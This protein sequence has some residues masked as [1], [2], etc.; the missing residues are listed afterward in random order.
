MEAVSSL[1]LK[2]FLC[3]FGLKCDFQNLVFLSMSNNLSCKNT[4]PTKKERER[5]NKG[6]NDSPF[7]WKN[8]NKRPT[9]EHKSGNDSVKRRSFVSEAFFSG[10]KLAE[11]LGRFWDDV[12]P[13]LHRDPASVV[14]ADGNV[15]VNARG[16]WGRH[17]WLGMC[18]HPVY[19]IHALY[20]LCALCLHCQCCINAEFTLC[21]CCVH[22]SR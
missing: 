18:S 22:C 3:K 5:G 2:L 8:V 19:T 20:T 6:E 14:F 10:A 7:I 16:R 9:L 17:R 15:E 4:L 12:R 13:Q 21:F 11:I 1:Y